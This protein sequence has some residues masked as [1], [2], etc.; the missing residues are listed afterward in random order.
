MFAPKHPIPM[1]TVFR[2][3]FL[4]NFGVAVDS[5]RR[6]I[7]AP[8]EPDEHHGEAYVSVVIAEMEKM[9]PAFL[10]RIFGVTYTQVV[11]RAVVRCRGERGVYFLR[12]D[13]DNRLMCALGNWLTFFRFNLAEV[14]WRDDSGHIH[15]DLASASRS[16][17]IRASYDVRGATHLLPASS[18]FASLDEAKMFL[19][20]LYAAFGRDTRGRT[21]RV[22]IERGAWDVA[23]VGDDRAEYG[24]MQPSALLANTAR[25]DSVFYVRDLPYHWHT[26][27]RFPP[28]PADQDASR[29][30]ISA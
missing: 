12:S 29:A 6:A 26:L 23:V 18:R 9:R 5:L 27:E 13:A 11:Y 25:V 4:V 8:I 22:R 19:V 10:P 1:R 30:L 7:P 14:H 17:D 2:R 16:A 20:E 15:F 24:F 21:S 3:C 28:A